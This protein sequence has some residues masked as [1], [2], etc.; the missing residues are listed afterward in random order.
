MITYKGFS[1]LVTP[2]KF[3]VTDFELSKRDLLNYFSIRK[4]EKL[5]QPNFGTI[6]WDLL[7]EP[8]NDD[9]QQLITDD[10]NRI[11]GYDPRLRAGQVSVTQQTNGFLIQITL[12]YVPSDQTETISLN[13]DQNSKNLT[14][15][16]DYN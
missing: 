10:I 6:I 4:G 15:I 2:K 16:V 13:F 1:T 12:S 14:S 8:L 7:F 9:I 5:M 11:I 3:K